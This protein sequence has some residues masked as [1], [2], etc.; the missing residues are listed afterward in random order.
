MMTLYKTPKLTLSSLGLITS[1]WLAYGLSLLLMLA[2]GQASAQIT[3][4]SRTSAADNGWR[5]VAYG[6][7]LFVAVAASG[8]EIGRA[9]V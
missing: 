5:S 1:T 7:G 3:W 8:T 2:Y 9:H 4:T 6:N